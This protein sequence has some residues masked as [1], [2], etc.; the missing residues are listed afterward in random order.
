MRS[1]AGHRRCVV[2][3]AMQAPDSA[4][5]RESVGEL[6]LRCSGALRCSP[7]RSSSKTIPCT[8]IPSPSR[9]GL[10]RRYLCAKRILVGETAKPNITLASC[11]HTSHW[12]GRVIPHFGILFAMFSRKVIGEATIL[13][14]AQSTGMISFIPLKALRYRKQ[15]LNISGKSF[16]GETLCSP[17]TLFRTSEF[18]LPPHGVAHD[19]VVMR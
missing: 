16:R 2:S 5:Y 4:R 14:P 6:K 15:H 17:M 10:P 12:S 9:L 13:K 3:Y 8:S 7:N 19:G 18:F 11:N 1:Q